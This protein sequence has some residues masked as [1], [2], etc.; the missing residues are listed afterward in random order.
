MMAH[1]YEQERQRNAPPPSPDHQ[2]SLARQQEQTTN[3]EQTIVGQM[4]AVRDE[5]QQI[6]LNLNQEHAQVASLLHAQ[7]QTAA[8]TDTLSIQIQSL[9]QEIAQLNRSGEDELNLLKQ[10]LQGSDD[11]Q[12]LL[13]ELEHIISK[14]KSELLEVKHKML[15][16]V[17]SLTEEKKL[18]MHYQ[19]EIQALTVQLQQRDRELNET[20]EMLAISL[21]LNQYYKAS[22]TNH[23]EHLRFFKANERQQ[24]TPEG[25]PQYTST[26][27]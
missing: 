18:N 15:S 1:N 17:S 22:L 14:Q 12:N 23:G 7:Q 10:K 25:M 9:L 20:N 13:Q 4:Q 21:Q 6:N 24:E 5:Y 2:A 27:N 16:L 8:Q 19:S 26:A 11:K 3:R